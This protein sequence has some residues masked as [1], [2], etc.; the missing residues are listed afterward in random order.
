MTADG[1]DEASTLAASAREALAQRR[2]E[3]AEGLLRRALAI[4]PDNAALH[5]DLGRA[6]NNL[7]R[8]ADAE[9]AFRRC[10]ALRPHDADIHFYLGH[11]LRAQD[12]LTEAQVELETACSL[13]P[14]VA[15]PWQALAGVVA[16]RGDLARA[17]ELYRRAVE[18][19]PGHW[20][21]R[22]N[23]AGVLEVSGR[24]DEAAA[25][26]D[27]LLTLAP[28]QADV[29]LAY[30]SLLQS[31]GDIGAAAVHFE[32]ALALSGANQ[33]A[34]AGLASVHEIRGAVDKGWRLVAPIIDAGGAGPDLRHIGARLL[35]RQ[36]EHARALALLEPLRSDPQLGWSQRPQLYYTLGEIHDELGDAK[37]AFESVTRANELWGVKDFDPDRHR[38]QVDQA[39]AF[40][41]SS[42]A[43]AL[44]RAAPRDPVPVFIVGMPRSGTS[45]VEQIL[46]SHSR[47]H[48]GGE[49]LDLP[50]V[51]AELARDACAV[52]AYPR[53]LL[54]LEGGM[55]D[56][57]ADRYRELY[58]AVSPGAAVTTDKLPANF[59]HLGLIEL[60][61]PNARV[62]HC[63]RHPLDTMV[64]IYFQN[65]HPHSQPFASDLAHIAA[66]FEQYER[67]MA[68][69]RSALE[70]P[71]FELDYEQLVAEQ[72]PVTRQLLE[73]L[74]L[75][76]EAGCLRFFD[77]RREVTT[78]SY[79]QVRRPVY[80]TSVGRHQR[81]LPFLGDLA[82]RFR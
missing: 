58:G 23:L 20:P 7:R 74:G 1:P 50:R 29:H 30:A 53:G 67:L 42:P 40:F 70:L 44:V 28:D 48:A 78:A 6:L 79:A 31:R 16:G 66:Y 14:G 72:E 32:R 2:P 51:A 18:L 47:V 49:R 65:F 73:F 36:G 39:I 64:S 80:S 57:A 63:R 55:L 12:R 54:S 59:L 33:Q 19:A 34:I 13:D 27:E 26:Y 35:R 9:S 52:E 41:G 71:L 25:E 43:R 62:I 75:P 3:V 82:E 81:Y 10:L 21:T 37:A 11:V 60:L 17:I 5:A 77:T 61:M 46:A 15:R 8:H 38:G 24:G 4:E 68:H 56:R 76:W 22:L 69:W 45:L